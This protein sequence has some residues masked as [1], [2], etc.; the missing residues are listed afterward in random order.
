MHMKQRGNPKVLNRGP[1]CAASLCFVVP[2]FEL[3]DCS[4]CRGA[5]SGVR[6]HSCRC[7]SVVVTGVL[8]ILFLAYWAIDHAFMLLPL[9]VNTVCPWLHIGPCIVWREWAFPFVVLHSD[10]TTLKVVNVRAACWNEI[11]LFVI[12]FQGFQRAFLFFHPPWC[13][14]QQIPSV[15][16]P[17]NPFS[18]PRPTSDSNYEEICTRDGPDCQ[19]SHGYFLLINLRQ[20]LAARASRHS[21]RLPE[22]DPIFCLNRH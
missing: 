18:L 3:T 15:R 7:Q 9:Q 12:M 1:C 17:R 21:S 19:R 8:F 14:P 16:H 20:E 13:T 5:S 2:L 4:N 10:T 6:S 11:F 22:V